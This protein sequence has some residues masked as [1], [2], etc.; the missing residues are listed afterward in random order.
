MVVVEL[1]VH[2]VRRARQAVEELF[3]VELRH[4]GVAR[5]PARAVAADQGPVT[6]DGRVV[7][8]EAGFVLEGDAVPRAVEAE[9]HDLPGGRAVRAQRPVGAVVA[10]RAEESAGLVDS[11]TG[12]LRLVRRERE[13]WDAAELAHVYGGLILGRLG[14]GAAAYL[15]AVEAD[16]GLG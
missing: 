1:E 11:E 4:L 2:D 15:G 16:D 5:V 10:G 7:V 3:P 14:R 13:V 6:V 9:A 8:R 12:C